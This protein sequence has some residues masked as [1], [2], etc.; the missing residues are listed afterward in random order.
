M[1]YSGDA[2]EQ[3]VRLSLETGEV[4]VKLAGEGAKQLAILLY[5]ILREQKKTKG[6]TRLT[7]MLRS[8]K[9]LK[10]FAVK[11]SDLQL[12]CREAKKYGVLYCVLKDRDATDGLTDIMVRA[13]DAS[14][15]N[16]IFER[17]NLAT[18]DMAEVRREIEQ[19][20]QEQQNDAPEAPATAE[21]M[22]EQ[23]VDDLLDAMLSPAPEQ[24]EE[25][26]VPERTTPEQDRDE[27]LEAVLG[28]SPTREE[29]QTENPT[30]ARNEKSRQSGPTSKPK[31]PTA[32]GTSEPQERSRPS[33][34]Q[35]LNDI[36]AEQKEKAS[37]GKEYK[38]DDGSRGVSYNVKKVFDISQ[39]RAEQRPAP[40]VARDERL[41]LKALMNNAPC[42]FSISNELP[43]GLNM[44]YHAESNVIYVRQGLDAPTIFRGLAQELAR[45]HMDRGGIACESPDFTVYSVS[46]MLCKRNGVSV[47]G[48]SFDRLPES[49]AM[50]D[51]K[52]L[53]AE[54]GVMR[55]VAGS[56][57]A[58][59]NRLFAAQEK[60]Q[61][62]RDGGAR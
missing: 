26:P 42:R 3:V 12:F 24:E 7:N 18:V 56:I 62:N 2:A 44:A 22:T 17:F 45:A 32:P 10:V 27:F 51:A 4:A 31:E 58:D 30:E 54:V 15:I 53:R 8:G 16:R 61:K 49:Y 50:M 41:L 34:R 13:E 28:A 29:G 9:E 25:L 6:K 36:K 52:A 11:D 46:Y 40:A 57:T 21:P 38:K 47:E 35:A 19:S 39:T 1:S 43:E 59:M 37:K 20:R 23:E 55:D 33:V 48:F 60:A 14:K 5:A